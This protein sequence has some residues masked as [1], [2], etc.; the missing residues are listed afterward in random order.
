MLFYLQKL[1]FILPIIDMNYTNFTI[2]Y[3]FSR[4]IISVIIF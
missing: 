3:E 1:K 2:Q 4:A